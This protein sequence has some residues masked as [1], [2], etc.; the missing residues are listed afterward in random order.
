MCVYTRHRS[1]PR[2]RRCCAACVSD[3]EKHSRVAHAERYPNPNPVR[4]FCCSFSRE[5]FSRLSMLS[6]SARGRIGIPLRM[7]ASSRTAGAP[8]SPSNLAPACALLLLLF[9][10]PVFSQ[11]C[12]SVLECLQ[13]TAPAAVASFT[14]PAGILSGTNNCG[15]RVAG[16]TSQ[17]GL[18]VLTMSGSVCGAT[19][20][21]PATI[22]DCSASGSRCLIVTNVNVTL[23]NIV[24][25][26]GAAPS[27]VM[28][29]DVSLMLAAVRQQLLASSVSGINPKLMGA[30]GMDGAASTEASLHAEP[31]G[32]RQQAARD[33]N[34]AKLY[35][36]WLQRSQTR[37]VEQRVF[38]GETLEEREQPP[39]PRSGSRRLLQSTSNVGGCVYISSPGGSVVFEQVTMLTFCC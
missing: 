27:A 23:R 32:W 20:A 10:A 25:T 15:I 37:Q 21:C 1:P 9:G 24:F 18:Q 38:S 36:S 31:R 2:P 33:L 5:T 17:G 26:G 8:G 4:S 29:A 12:S 34:G 16:N 7:V 19:D 30:G 14:L 3:G 6:N 11:S 28:P 39:L 22:I 13:Q 35:R